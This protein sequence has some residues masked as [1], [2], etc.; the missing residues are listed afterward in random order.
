M[1]N[2]I[3]IVLVIIFTIGSYAQTDVVVTNVPNPI[4]ENFNNTFNPEDDATWYSS[5][6]GRYAAVFRENGQKQVVYYS[7][8]GNWIQ[9]NRSIP[10]HDL[11]SPV[12][13]RFQDTEFGEWKID[14]VS[15]VRSAQYANTK[16]YHIEAVKDNERWGIYYD[17]EG[18]LVRKREEEFEGE[19]PMIL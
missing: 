6:E 7:E 8:D 17:E 4:V 19:L 14:Q 12:M 9:T 2:I 10:V 11:P 18:N 16:L 15:E 3:V 5:T 13:E 1:K